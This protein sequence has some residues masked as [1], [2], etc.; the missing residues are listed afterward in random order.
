MMYYEE[1]HDGAWERIEVSGEMLTGRA[2]HVIYFASPEAWQR[3]PAWARNRR[4]EIIARITS[5]FR[6]PDY[7]YYGLDAHTPPSPAS[8]IPNPP[9]NRPPGRRPPPGQ[10]PLLIA[11]VLL[12]IL[13]GGI[14]WFVT[15][16]VARGET[17][18]PVRFSGGHRHVVR[19]EKPVLFW[20]S[21]GV[22]LVIGVGAAVLGVLGLK[23]S[24]KLAA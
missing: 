7:E 4:D 6:P 20:G 1:R 12:L 11:V 18:L 24:R 15:R 16:S 23:E 17:S 10:R 22:Y 8:T 9:I 5:E 14:G 13:A 2:H 19:A 21:L 3:Y